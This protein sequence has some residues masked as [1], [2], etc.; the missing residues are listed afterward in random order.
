MPSLPIKYQWLRRCRSQHRRQKCFYNAG[1][2]AL[3]LAAS[4]S[5]NQFG[6]YCAALHPDIADPYGPNH[7]TFAA[8]QSHGPVRHRQSPAGARSLLTG[9]CHQAALVLCA[10]HQRIARCRCICCI[11]AVGI[12]AHSITKLFVQRRTAHHHNIF[13]AQA[14]IFKASITTFM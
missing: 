4:L 14:L 3:I 7:L 8:R 1:D 13:V 5:G 11:A 6:S 9:P 10:L 12:G 2:F